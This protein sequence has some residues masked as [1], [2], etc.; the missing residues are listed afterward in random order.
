M[1]EN[2]VNSY[3]EKKPMSYQLRLQKNK[4]SFSIYIKKDV[5]LKADKLANSQMVSRGTIIERALEDYFIKFPELKD[6]A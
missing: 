2:L 5:R 6:A 4:C 1:L 3:H